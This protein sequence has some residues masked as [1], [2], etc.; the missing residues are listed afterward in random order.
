MLTPHTVVGILFIILG[1]LLSAISY[2]RRRQ[3]N[4]DFSD[5]LRPLPSHVE[6]KRVF[7]G[8]FI[9][10][11]WIVLAVTVTVVSAQVLLVVLILR[12]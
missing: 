9:T 4:W 1:G 8:P 3:S 6:K 10:A 11:G 2:F 12:L 5:Q 7:G